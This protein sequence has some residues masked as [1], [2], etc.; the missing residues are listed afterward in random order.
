MFC[1]RGDDPSTTDNAAYAL[2]FTVDTGDTA[3]LGGTVDFWFNGQTTTV[4]LNA[5]ADEAVEDD[6][7]ATWESL[8]NV[9]SAT[10]FNS[11]VN[12]VTKSMTWTVKLVFADGYMNNLHSHDGNPSIDEFACNLYVLLSTP[13]LHAIACGNRAPAVCSP[14]GGRDWRVGTH[15]MCYRRAGPDLDNQ[16][17]VLRELGCDLHSRDR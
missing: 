9:A 16:W 8:P 17:H 1:P 7:K 14:Q 11:T 2:Q 12:W 3:Q 10:C 15:H 13:R 4:S 6:C 5:N